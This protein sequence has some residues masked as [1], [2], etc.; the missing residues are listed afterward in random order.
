MIAIITT[1]SST[2]L[3]NSYFSHT[4]EAQKRWHKINVLLL[5]PTL[6]Y[7]HCNIGLHNL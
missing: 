3:S 5:S 2:A 6:E 7:C 1:V 4:L